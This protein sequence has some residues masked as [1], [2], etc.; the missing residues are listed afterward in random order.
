MTVTVVAG[1]TVKVPR[2]V[3]GP[4]TPA[5][6]G[7]SLPGAPVTGW[8]IVRVPGQPGRPCQGF[9]CRRA[10][11]STT[12][13]FSNRE[14]LERRY[15]E[16]SAGAQRLTKEGKTEE[17]KRVETE[18]TRSTRHWNGQAGCPSR[19]RCRYCLVS[20]CLA[21]PSMLP[22]PGPR[23]T[24]QPGTGASPS[25]GGVEGPGQEGRGQ[26][27]VSVVANGR[28]GRRSEP[29]HRNFARKMVGLAARPTLR[30]CVILGALSGPHRAAKL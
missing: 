27:V 29:H 24:P 21:S 5:M 4:T 23:G 8:T 30:S 19:H 7:A 6:P 20:S 13:G 10:V 18:L 15:K 1:Q 26:E 14:A 17:A 2:G 28:V 16:F 22:G 9:N 11:P 12:R 25:G 3:P